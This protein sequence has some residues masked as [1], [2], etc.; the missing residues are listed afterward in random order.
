M[1]FGSETRIR[2]CLQACR[3]EQIE[4][5]GFSRCAVTGKPQRLKP[6]RIVAFNGIA[7]AMP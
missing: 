4:S 3:K 6:F 2:A 5:A 7:E 1:Q